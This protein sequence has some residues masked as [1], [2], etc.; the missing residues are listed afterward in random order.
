MTLPSLI[1]PCTN[2]THLYQTIYGTCEDSCYPLLHLSILCY[3]ELF[4]SLLTLYP[5]AL[6]LKQ[7]PTANKTRAKQNDNYGI[8]RR[9]S[10]NYM[11]NIVAQ[12]KYAQYANQTTA[13]EGPGIC[14]HIAS[15]WTGSLKFHPQR[16][17]GAFHDPLSSFPRPTR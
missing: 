13:R 17:S 9:T 1:N 10:P 5:N 7:T 16:C 4:S 14:L 8:T 12:A 6:F 3:P 15:F 2:I 11:A